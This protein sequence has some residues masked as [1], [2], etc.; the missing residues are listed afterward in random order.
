MFWFVEAYVGLVR[1]LSTYGCPASAGRTMI[2]I[3]LYLVAGS[4]W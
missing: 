4:G 3:L 2:F 1:L